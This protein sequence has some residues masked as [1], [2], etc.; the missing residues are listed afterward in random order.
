MLKT[1]CGDIIGSGTDRLLRWPEV[2]RIVGYSRMHISRLEK[3]NNF[4]KRVQLG[5]N[6]VGW[7][8][9]EVL[10]WARSRPRG[11]LPLGARSARQPFEAA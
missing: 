4:P 9:S 2:E 7:W 1:R 11:H 8:E 3:A 6:T 10:D 5:P